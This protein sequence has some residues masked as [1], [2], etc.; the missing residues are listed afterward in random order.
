ME[1]KEYCDSITAELSGWKYKVDNIASRFDRASS[2]DKKRIVNEVNELHTISN[3][4]GRRI[5]GLKKDCLKDF[6]RGR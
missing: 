3:E 4:L 2:E 6:G 5:E 1:V